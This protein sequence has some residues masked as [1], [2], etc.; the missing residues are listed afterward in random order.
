MSDFLNLFYITTLI[1]RNLVSFWIPVQPLD[2]P[3]FCLSFSDHRLIII[4]P[5]CA[6]DPNRNNFCVWYFQLSILNPKCLLKDHRIFVWW[7][8]I[9]P[10]A[11]VSE[12]VNNI[13]SFVP[14]DALHH[15]WMMPDHHIRSHINGKVCKPFL[16]RLNVLC[17][18]DTR[19]HADNDHFRLLLFQFL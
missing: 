3:R 2:D 10:K 18:L 5:V 4:Y 11:E 13:F 7:V 16:D 19:M 17:I 6:A 15:M 1:N 9:A 8:R 14:V 12:T